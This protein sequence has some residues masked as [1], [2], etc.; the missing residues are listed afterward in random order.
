MFPIALVRA[1]IRG[2]KLAAIMCLGVPFMWKAGK[3]TLEAY[4]KAFVSAKS[5]YAAAAA[6]VEEMLS[7]MATLTS[8]GAERRAQVTYATKLEGVFT[9]LK[10]SAWKDSWGLSFL[11][12]TTPPSP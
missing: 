4:M 1:F 8:I 9:T 7:S 2:P 5:A 12:G 11:F 3:M 10:N 6:Y